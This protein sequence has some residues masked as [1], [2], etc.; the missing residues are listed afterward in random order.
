MLFSIA[1]EVPQDEQTAYGLT[2]PALCNENYGCFS[3]ADHVEDVAGMAREA[4][5]LTITDMI[6]SGCY[7][8]DQIK[9]PGPVVYQKT[10]PEFDGQQ[11]FVIEVDLSELEGKPQRINISLPD[12]LIRRIDSRVKTQEDYRDRSHFLAV[13]AKN[14]LLRMEG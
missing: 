12:V 5:L 9:D 10:H 14:E 13:A 7:S 1:V 6:E 8:L 2:I 4:I 11:W 3:A